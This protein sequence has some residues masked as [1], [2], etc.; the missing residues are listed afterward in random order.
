MITKQIKLKK[1]IGDGSFGK[2]MEGK[3]VKEKH[4]RVRV[5]MPST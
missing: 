1:G 3:M 2:R 5:E 4:K